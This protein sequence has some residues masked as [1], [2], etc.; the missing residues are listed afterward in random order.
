MST[1]VAGI[2][3]FLAALEQARPRRDKPGHD[4]G[5]VVQYGRIPA[6]GPQQYQKSCCPC[7]EAAIFSATVG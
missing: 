3:V 2:H 1:L 6:A 5:K 7:K 4:S